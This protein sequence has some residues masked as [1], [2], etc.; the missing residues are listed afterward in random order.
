MLGQNQCSY[1]ILNQ[2]NQKIHQ[3][4]PQY[5]G[6]KLGIQISTKYSV[7]TNFLKLY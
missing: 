5:F 3:L 2:I 1:S 6:P 7:L 4:G